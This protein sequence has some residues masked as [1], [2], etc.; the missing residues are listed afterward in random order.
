[1]LALYCTWQLYCVKLVLLHS[2]LDACSALAKAVA[3]FVPHAWAVLV[4]SRFPACLSADLAL[5]CAEGYLDSLVHIRKCRCNMDPAAQRGCLQTRCC[6]PILVLPTLNRPPA[7]G[8]AATLAMARS[9]FLYT[10]T[11]RQHHCPHTIS[12][13]NTTSLEPPGLRQTNCKHLESHYLLTSQ[14]ERLS[15]F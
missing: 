12:I 15:P 7:P 3:A 6:L 13:A 11:T 8:A 1:V 10:R 2:A 9:Q 5:G 4:V 14:T